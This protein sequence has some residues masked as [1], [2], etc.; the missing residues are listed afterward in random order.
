[1]SPEEITKLFTANDGSYRFAR[2]ERP[3]V[4]VVF[5]VDEATLAVI[6]GAIEAVV[7][8]AGHKM[9]ETDPELG[10]NL[11]LFFF[12]DWDELLTIPKLNEL[13]PNL[14]SVV[15][16][17][18]IVKATQYRTF[19]FEENG[20]IQACFSFT[21]VH[22]DVVDQPADDLALSQAVGAILAWSSRAFTNASPLAVL[23]DTGGAVLRPEI[24]DIIHVGYDQVMPASATD[25]AHALRLSARIMQQGAG[26]HGAGQR[27]QATP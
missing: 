3:I 17:L 4:P 15:Q 18:K 12:T 1:M 27:G 26:Q 16:R 24:A 8:L 2:W 21:C 9:A 7:T 19:R 5:G 25:A 20:A 10:A 22:G 14:A 13:V 23:P 11:M 6:K